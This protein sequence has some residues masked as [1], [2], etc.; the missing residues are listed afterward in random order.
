MVEPD[1]VPDLIPETP[2]PDEPS[3]DGG[4]PGGVEG[5]VPGG[6]VG[7]VVGGE[8]GGVIG[9]VLGGVLGGKLGPIV[10]TPDVTLPELILATKVKPEFPEIAR[11]ARLSGKVICEAV[12]DVEGNVTDVKI[13][14]SP[15]PIFNEPTVEALRQWK[16]KPAILGGQPVSV[17]LTVVVDF[18]LK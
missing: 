18:D 17:Y 11:R 6:V 12:I 7:G 8:I 1:I 14:S 3:A 9:G 15:S 4:V 16:Y 13:L 5:G 2:A 10:P